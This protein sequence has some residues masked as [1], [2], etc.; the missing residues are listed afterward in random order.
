MTRV[1][2][3]RI[4]LF[5]IPVSVCALCASGF[6]LWLA[7]AVELTANSVASIVFGFTLSS[8]IMFRYA[9]RKT[10]DEY[11]GMTDFLRIPSRERLFQGEAVS[12]DIS[13][14]YEDGYSYTLIKPEKWMKLTG[15]RLLFDVPEELPAGFYRYT[16]RMTEIASGKSA[17]VS[18]RIEVIAPDVLTGDEIESGFLKIESSSPVDVITGTASDGSLRTWIYASLPSFLKITDWGNNPEFNRWGS[19]DEDGEND[20]IFEYVSMRRYGRFLIKKTLVSSHK[21]FGN[22]IKGDRYDIKALPDGHIGMEQTIASMMTSD[23]PLV[24]GKGMIPVLFIHGYNS[25]AM[26]IGG[27]K[28]TWGGLPL[29]LDKRNYLVSEFRWR[30]SQRFQDAAAAL[31]EA[32]DILYQ[33]TGNRVHYVAHSF[34]GLLARTYIQGLADGK[35]YAGDVASLVTFGTPHSGI[36][37]DECMRFGAAMPAGQ[38]FDMSITSQIS[39]FQA[40]LDIEGM[41]SS[42]IFGTEPEAGYIP[43]MLCDFVR[44]RIPDGVRICNVIGLSNKDMSDETEDGDKVITYGGQR[45]A[46][47]LTVRG[48]EPL[49]TDY[50]G[51]GGIVSETVL[52]ASGR[53]VRPGDHFIFSPDMYGYVHSPL[54]GRYRQ[55]EVYVKCADPNVCS[56][57][58]FILIRDWLDKNS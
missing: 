11:T 25:G 17:D 28:S 21:V 18:G 2:N 23:R 33:V 37:Q 58:A 56:H 27:G 30:T 34:G 45:F 39:G 19:P 32:T 10:A 54:I 20:N 4:F 3:A 26:G 13:V 35:P 44:H 53:D 40:G 9:R 43:A 1:K 41:E 38:C 31:A 29:M 16:V 15:G 5:Y 51:F 24:R 42:E 57:P 49:L 8:V 52:G 48:V 12:Y 6:F 47:M 50:Q 36:C 46:P 14:P 55:S 7:G 22:R